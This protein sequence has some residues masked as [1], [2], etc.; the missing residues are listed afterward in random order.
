MVG[1]FGPSWADPKGASSSLTVSTK[2]G[3]EETF[4]LELP[5]LDSVINNLRD[6][7]NG[8]KLDSW[9]EFDECPQEREEHLKNT[10]NLRGGGR[11]PKIA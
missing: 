6:E 9:E 11:R 8:S 10:L 2:V 5:G 4:I 1:G 3:G 7:R